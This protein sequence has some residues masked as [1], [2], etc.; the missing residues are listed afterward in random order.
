MTV[1]AVHTADL[2]TDTEKVK[3]GPVF[4]N[5]YSKTSWEFYIRI[6]LAFGMYLFIYLI[7]I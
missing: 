2:F 6:Y 5:F 4:R 3:V 7:K 1:V